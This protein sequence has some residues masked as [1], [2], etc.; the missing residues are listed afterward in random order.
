MSVILVAEEDAGSAEQIAGLL[1]SGG[2]SVETAASHAAALRA[3]AARQPALLLASADLAEAPSLLAAFSRRRGG[4]GAIALVPR[5]A[6]GQASAEDY[7]ADDLLAKPCSP[8]TLE[9]TIRRFLS[10]SPP[11][12]AASDVSRSDVSRSDVSRSDVSAAEAAQD[13]RQLTSADIFGDVLAEVEAEAQR[14]KNARRARARTRRAD[15][16]ERKLEE[17]PNGSFCSAF[18]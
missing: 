17:T 1:R 6:A 14:E 11:A 18:W 15:E 2:W 7:R 9:R 10:R 5:S 13:G 8:E 3:A 12:A 16:I 4:P